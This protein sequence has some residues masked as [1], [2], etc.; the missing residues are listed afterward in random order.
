VVMAIGGARFVVG[1]AI[2]FAASMGMVFVHKMIV[3]GWFQMSECCW[4]VAKKS[5]LGDEW[6]RTS[7][8]EQISGDAMA[9]CENSVSN[10]P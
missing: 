7:L 5:S 8:V 4:R 3:A 10:P 1:A 2:R 6:S 9:A